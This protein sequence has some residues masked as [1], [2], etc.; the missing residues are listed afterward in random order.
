MAAAMA[1][2]AL[3]PSPVAVAVLA[4]V[5]LEAANAEESPGG[6]AWRAFAAKPATKA[7]ALT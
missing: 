5:R 1:S 4:A 3:S 2:F 6:P 7:G